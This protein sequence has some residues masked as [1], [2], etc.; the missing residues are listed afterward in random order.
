MTPQR[1][2]QIERVFR[3]AT[4]RRA[5][6]LAGWPAWRPLQKAGANG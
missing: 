6:G 5:P 2:A 1:L 4:G 3:Q